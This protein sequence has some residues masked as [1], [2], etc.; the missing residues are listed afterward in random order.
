MT[1]SQSFRR[2]VCSTVPALFMTLAA[3]SCAAV[4]DA[5]APPNTQALE[6][7]EHMISPTGIV[8]RSGSWCWFGDPRAIWREG[9][10]YLGWINNAG[11]VQVGQYDP[12]TETVSTVTLH[13][14]FEKDDHDNPAILTQKGGGITVFYSGHMGKAMFER[15]LPDPAHFDYWTSERKLALSPV[16][17]EKQGITYPNPYRLSGEDGAVYLFWR[18][19]DWK[20]QWAR[21]TD[22]GQSW[23][24]LGS[25]VSRKENTWR[26]RPYTKYISDGKSRVHMIFNDGHPRQEA[27]N[28]VYYA[29]YEDGAWH[30]ANGDVIAKAGELPFEPSEADMIYDAASGDAG[31]AW[32]WDVELDKNGKPVIVFMTA[33]EEK[34]HRYRYGFWDGEKWTSREICKAGGWMP[35]TRRGQT[36]REPHYSGG[37]VLDPDD[38]S[39]IY[40]SRPVNGVF[41]I[42]CWKTADKGVSWTSEAVTSKSPRNNVRPYIARGEAQDGPRLLWMYGDY[43]HYTNF[44]TAIRTDKPGEPQ[45]PK[46]IAAEPQPNVES[47][48]ESIRSVMDWQLRACAPE[49][50][51]NNLR[52]WVRGVLGTG[53]MATWRVTGDAKYLDA[54][55][56]MSEA[57][58]WKLGGQ[59]HNA[60][61]HVIAQTYAE[62]YQVK[63][64]PVRIADLKA[65]CDAIMADHR[66]GRKTYWWCDSLYMGPPAWARLS[67]VTGDPVYLNYVD[68]L[69]WDS[70]EYLYDTEE[71]LYFRDDSFFNL[72]ASNGAKVFWARGNGWVIAGITRMLDYMPADFPSRP[73]YI[74]TFKEM[75]AKIA[76]IQSE[77]GLWRVSLLDPGATPYGETSGSAF[78]CFALAWGVNNGLLERA[79][80]EPVIKKAWRA[81]NAC[82][83]P[84]GRIGY[85]QRIGVG[86]DSVEPDDT[87]EY[88]CAA[89]VLAGGEVLKMMGR[90]APELKTE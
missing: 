81:L 57:N 3:V 8:S 56:A 38:I 42:E 28:N 66:E 25:I 67:V 4:N 68:G 88:G 40:L 22:D 6:V 87:Q 17:E 58:G 24:F 79:E 72:R 26:N 14:A 54:A 48:L 64:D 77:D 19:D 12:E 84:D 36:E 2:A 16:P 13:A 44:H 9:K 78:Y 10:L 33:P 75:S 1:L 31:R 61:D 32:V 23:E 65:R 34:D 62:L 73:R 80:Y 55:V 18:G 59:K 70:T 76:S 41:E 49:G 7:S 86:P 90:E 83:R 29:Y 53:I 45:Q 30:R 71:H 35:L 69:W 15:S 20:P 37:I 51:W 60:D 21:S 5:A 47:S 39:T 74:Q 89:F 27:T 50:R 11:D 85:V 46:E 82:V 43:Y 63:A 52:N